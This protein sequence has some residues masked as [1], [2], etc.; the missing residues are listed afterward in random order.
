MLYE[1]GNAVFQSKG[2]Y[3][4]KRGLSDEAPGGR[5]GLNKFTGFGISK[6]FGIAFKSDI[7]SSTS[8]SSSDISKGS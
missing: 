5:G 4:F 3:F 1:V 8:S 7:L 6:K 2:A